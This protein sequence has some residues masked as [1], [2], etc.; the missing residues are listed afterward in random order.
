VDVRR[1]FFPTAVAEEKTG[2]SREE[3]VRDFNAEQLVRMYADGTSG[4]DFEDRRVPSRRSHFRR[5]SI[6]VFAQ[7][8]QRP[9]LPRREHHPGAR[10]AVLGTL[11]ATKLQ[12]R[13]GQSER[14]AAERAHW[15]EKG[16][17]VVAPLRSLI[18]DANP[19]VLALDR[20]GWKDR[21]ESLWGRWAPLRDQLALLGAAHPSPAIG[22]TV[23]EIVTAV[24]Q[25]LANATWLVGYFV[26]PTGPKEGY[27]EAQSAAKASNQRAAELAT[28]LLAEVR[29]LRTS[30]RRSRAGAPARAL[31]PSLV[32]RARE[33]LRTTAH[34]SV[35]Q[36]RTAACG[37]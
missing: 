36:S 15:R 13:H 5:S 27:A 17:E 18:D 24:P 4:V 22:K 37:P 6:T 1:S 19:L 10:I 14:E 35:H 23:A 3:L 32:T 33:E 21:M 7:T 12:L 9:N 16:A 34:Q 26:G 31:G 25:A 8:P 28:E 2:C 11:A 30:R 29:G 20:E